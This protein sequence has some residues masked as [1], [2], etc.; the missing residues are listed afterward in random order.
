MKNP[1]N[2]SIVSDKSTIKKFQ[3]LKKRLGK[4]MLTGKFYALSLKKQHQLV[5]RFNRSYSQLNKITQGSLA[6]GLTSIILASAPNE[7][8]QAQTFTKEGTNLFGVTVAPTQFVDFDNDGDLDFFVTTPSTGETQFFRNTGTPTAPSFVQEGGTNPFGITAVVHQ[9]MVFHDIDGDGDVDAFRTFNTTE[10]IEFLRNTGGAF[11][12]EITG[13]PFGLEVLGGLFDVGELTFAD[14]DG[15][16]DLDAFVGSKST[17][18]SDFLDF[19]RN[20]G[21]V[22][23]PVFVKETSPAGFP[24]SGQPNFADVDGDGDLDVFLNNFNNS[25][26]DKFLWNTGSATSSN[27]VDAGSELFGLPDELNVFGDL[28]NDGYSDAFNGTMFYRNPK[29][30]APASAPSAPIP[31]LSQWGIMILGLLI[32]ILGVFYIRTKEFLLVE[33]R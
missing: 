14:I 17:F 21:S 26:D 33:K 31:T 6:T 2:S 10:N 22:T 15:D 3:Q 8:L 20:T 9:K 25:A 11:T 23:N 30:N 29:I 12:S 1:I 24:S 7:G 18:T 19:F 16:G 28:D 4:L 32:M 5:R 13:K 27:F